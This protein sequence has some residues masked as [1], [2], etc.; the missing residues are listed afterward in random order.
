[1]SKYALVIKTVSDHLKR[2]GDVIWLLNKADLLSLNNQT[3]FFEVGLMLNLNISK[4]LPHQHKAYFTSLINPS[5]AQVFKS[6]LKD[7]IFTKKSTKSNK[8]I[9]NNPQLLLLNRAR[10]I[11][12]FKCIQLSLQLFLDSENEKMDLRSRH[13]D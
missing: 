10:Q 7:K 9:I 6:N 12:C 4:E 11:N 8:L 5:H 3:N 2:N 13:L 1:L